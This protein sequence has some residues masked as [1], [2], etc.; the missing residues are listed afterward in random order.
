[1]G[2]VLAA[3]DIFLFPNGTIIV[4]F[5]LFLIILFVFYRYVVPPLTK[6]MSERQEML[7]KQA[8]DRAE[9][10]R[11][12]EAAEERYRAAMAEA[13]AEAAAIRDEA[14]ADAQRIRDE[15]REKT[16]R[17]VERIRQQ[18]EVALAKQ[19]E[20]AVREL[21]GEIGGLST[22]LAARILGEP[23]GEDGPHRSTVDR[24]I[25]ELDEE[26]AADGRRVDAGGAG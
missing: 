13:R 20:Q 19:R 24:F 11:K 15:M 1:M 12:V 23:L 16:D 25:A 26:Q 21:R 9:S 14:R 5:V 2:T 17:E 10:A 4:E 3:E 8:E 6:A 22:Q 18:G 7:K